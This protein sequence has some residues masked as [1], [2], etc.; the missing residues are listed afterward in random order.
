MSSV[1]SI[2]KQFYERPRVSSH[3]KHTCTNSTVGFDRALR[4]R[5]K[6][7]CAK[8]ETDVDICQTEKQVCNFFVHLHASAHLLNFP[9]TGGKITES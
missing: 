1:C 6:W 2:R 3:K 8:A 5:K 7:E 9:I 4:V